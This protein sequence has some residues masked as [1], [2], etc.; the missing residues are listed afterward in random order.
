MQSTSEGLMQQVN[1]THLAANFN[2]M[3]PLRTAPRVHLRNIL[4]IK[5]AKS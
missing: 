1:T 2:L 3:C 4:M 5:F